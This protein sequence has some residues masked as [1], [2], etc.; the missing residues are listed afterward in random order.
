M[1]GLWGLPVVYLIENNLYGMG[2]AVERAAAVEPLSKRACIADDVLGETFDGQD[3]IVV[4]E[5]VDRATRRAREEK[6]PSVLEAICYRYMGHSM[7]DAAYGTYRDK[8]EVTQWQRERD[9]IRR[10]VEKLKAA[11][12]IEGEEVERIDEDAR[13]E[14]EA[15]VEFARASEPPAVDALY[16]DVYADPYPD[17]RRRDPWR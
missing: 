2:T 9:P 6:R 16:D 15:A 8:A 14:A 11:E 1:A 10:F 7:A 5:A 3:V 12:L 17:P 13:A 4:R